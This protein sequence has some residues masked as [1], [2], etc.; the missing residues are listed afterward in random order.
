MKIKSITLKNFRSYSGETTVSFED[1]TAFVGR[2]DI[3]KSTILEALDIFFY[4]GK[5]IIKLEKMISIWYLNPMVIQKSV[6]LY[7]LQ[8]CRIVL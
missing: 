3:G 1:L 8:N 4:D 5:G 7:D 2:N 6:F